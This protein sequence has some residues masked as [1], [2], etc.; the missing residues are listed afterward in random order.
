MT[1]GT[2][3]TLITTDLYRYSGEKRLRDFMYHYLFSPG[4]NYTFWMRLCA[5]LQQHLVTKIVFF[6]IAWWIYYRKQIRYGIAISYKQAIG[7]GFYISH[8]GGIVA[9]EHAVIGKNCN[10][11]H[12]VTIG[13]TRRGERQ[14]VPTIGD[15]VYIGPGAKIIGAV[16]VGNY[17]AI[18]ANC[19]VTRDVP[20]HAVVVG[21]PAKVISYDGSNGYINNTD[22]DENH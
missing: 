18:G 13:V 2:L 1:L 11:S 6:P 19:V 14:G 7:T 15:N 9:N 21:I 10:L 17:A 12:D 16:H 8:N 5:F 3:I 22:Y 4:F 20:D